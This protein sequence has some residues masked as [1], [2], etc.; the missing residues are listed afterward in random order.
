MKLFAL[1]PLRT[2]IFSW[3]SDINPGL[4]GPTIILHAATKLLLRFTYHRRAVAFIHRNRHAALSSE[5]MDVLSS[6]LASKYVAPATRRLVL[7]DLEAKLRFK[8]EN[9]RVMMDDPAG[10]ELVVEMLE[11]PLPEVR[12]LTC[13][14]LGHLAVDKSTTSTVVCNFG[15]KLVPLIR[16]EDDKVVEKAIWAFSAAVRFH[17][18]AQAFIDAKLLDSVPELLESS[19]P[20]V[21]TQTCRLVG[22]LASHVQTTTA[23]L[24]WKPCPRLAALL[25]DE[26][27]YVVHAAVYALTQ[28]SRTSS[29]ATAVLDAKALEHVSQFLGPVQERSY[30]SVFQFEMVQD[31]SYEL[32]ESLFRHEF[33]VPA[34]LRLDICAGLVSVLQAARSPFPYKFHKIP[35]S[36]RLTVATTLLAGISE[37]PG[38]VSAVAETG[39]LGAIK[40]VECD[41]ALPVDDRV[42]ANMHRI[43]ANIARYEDRNLQRRI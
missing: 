23:V 16:D 9:R 36:A 28:I 34:I 7:Q 25:R 29:G 10:L 39:V 11:S 14:I 12:C 33:A 22:V 21:R 18:G 2:S 3:W 8:E 13:T 37:Y 24:E 1:Q 6:Y 5:S 31:R 41:L 40:W 43:Q 26:D 32:L 20:F 4:R 27:F 35:H 15:M 30:T 19:R 17:C 42:R 38:G